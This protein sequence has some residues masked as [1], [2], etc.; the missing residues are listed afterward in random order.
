[1]QKI[2]ICLHSCLLMCLLLS[3]QA[4]FLSFSMFFWIISHM[5]TRTKSWLLVRSQKYPEFLEWNWIAK[6]NWQLDHPEAKIVIICLSPVN[7]FSCRIYY[8]EKYTIIIIIRIAYTAALQSLPFPC[9][10][11]LWPTLQTLLLITDKLWSTWNCFI[12]LS[13]VTIRESRHRYCIV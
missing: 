3:L 5:D 4:C 7:F 1:M 9:K 11:S 10:A 6:S 8:C 2:S 12:C 13:Y